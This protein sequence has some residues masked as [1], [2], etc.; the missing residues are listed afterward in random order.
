MIR[1]ALER[2]W[3]QKHK[4]LLAVL[5]LP[6]SWLFKLIIIV[7]RFVLS[8]QQRP[9]MIPV[10]VIGNLSVG[11]NGKTPMIISLA[12]ELQKI[13]LKVGIVS[14][15]YGAKAK[16]FPLLVSTDSLVETVGDEPL[17]IVKKTACPLVISPNRVEAILHL[18]GAYS[19][20]VVLCDDGL[21][22]Y[23]MHRDLELLLIGSPLGLG[24]ECLLPAGP[25]REPKSRL[26][27]VDFVLSNQRTYHAIKA[28][29]IKLDKFY[30]L[31]DELELSI[32]QLKDKE[33]T[34]VTAIAKPERFFLFLHNLGLSF[35]KRAFP[36]HYFFTKED[37]SIKQGL[38]LMSEKDAIKCQ[39]FAENIVVV[40]IN[41]VLEPAF[42]QDFINKLKDVHQT[43]GVPCIQ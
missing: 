3:W 37:L 25:L 42:W 7:R 24:N 22:H 13:G 4:S 43:G 10:V 31:K 1:K 27:Q 18:Q 2:C 5:L 15:G 6:L 12:N 40:S 30:F 36:D 14:R 26:Q 19:L 16:S 21:Q 8:K 32:E 20:D 29:S 23:R 9:F 38:I 28:Y 17:L 34:V 11:G 35:S 39:A 33:L 41:F